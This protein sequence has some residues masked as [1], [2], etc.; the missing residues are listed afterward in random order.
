[1]KYTHTLPSSHR[2]RTALERRRLQAAKLFTKG[3]TQAEV[4][5]QLKVTREAARKWHQAWLQSGP[6]ALKSAGQPGPKPRLTPEKLKQVERALLLGPTAFGFATQIWTL[7]RIAQVIQRVARVKYHPGHV[8]YVL[9]NL[10][11]T[12]QKPATKARE[13]DEAAIQRWIKTTWPRLKKK[14]QELVQS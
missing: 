10:N 3:R 1:M 6:E 14:Q 2:D 4:A 11:W 12:C 5:R 13:R 8:W 9:K 7:A